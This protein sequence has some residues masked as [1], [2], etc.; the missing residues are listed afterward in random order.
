MFKTIQL[1]KSTNK[2]DL[3]NLACFTHK[4]FEKRNKVLL[5][6]ARNKLF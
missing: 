2:T 4:E 5:N 3:K 1:P 6:D